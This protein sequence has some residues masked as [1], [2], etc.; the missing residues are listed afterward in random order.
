[1]PWG[2]VFKSYGLLL[3]N[4][5]RLSVLAKGVA[6]NDNYDEELFAQSAILTLVFA[7]EALINSVIGDFAPEEFKAKLMKLSLW[8]KFACVPGLCGGIVA[9]PF[10]PEQE[11]FK[12][13]LAM[14]ATRHEWV[15]P[16]PAKVTMDQLL[17]E[18]SVTADPFPELPLHARAP[19]AD[20]AFHTIKALVEWLKST[21]PDRITNEWLRASEIKWLDA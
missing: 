9:Q 3:R 18:E 13:F 10:D 5:K 16:K 12:T 17:G 14:V 1:M 20:R 21:M 4:G 11:P 2:T 15:H 7:A 8:K 6:G 19:H